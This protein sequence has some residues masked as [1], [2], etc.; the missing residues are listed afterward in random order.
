MFYNILVYSRTKWKKQLA[1]RVKLAYRQFWQIPNAAAAISF[2]S[3]YNFS[4]GGQQHPMGTPHPFSTLLHQNSTGVLPF[5]I[6]ASSPN[7]NKFTQ[8]TSA[9]NLAQL[10]QLVGVTNPASLTSVLAAAAAAGNIGQTSPLTLNKVFSNNPQQPITPN[11]PP[12]CQFPSGLSGNDAATAA[13]EDAPDVNDQL[14]DT[15]DD[16]TAED[17]DD[18]PNSSSDFD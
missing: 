1:S 13:L 7:S 8:D 6:M 12:L 3:L 5:G 11:T 18:H 16:V 15:M 14:S 2:P 4:A 9:V 17:A 10:A